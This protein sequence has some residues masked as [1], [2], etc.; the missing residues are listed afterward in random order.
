MSNN[1]KAPEPPS[2]WAGQLL[3]FTCLTALLIVLT[4][5]WNALGQPHSV[6]FWIAVSFP[7]MHQV[8]VWLAWR[9]ELHSS[10]V[11]KW[12]GFGGYLVAFFL[13]F[14]GRFLS[15]AWLAFLDRGSL[16]L[17]LVSHVLLTL[18][19]LMPGVYAMYSVRRYFGMA[20]AAGGDHFDHRFRDMPLVNK[21]IFRF[22]DNGMYLYAFLLFWAIAIGLNSAAALSVA[23]F[24]HAYIWVHFYATEKPDMDYLYGSATP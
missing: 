20:R 19:L 10:T 17:T 5:A 1:L 12:I 13:L 14:S 8:W 18:I 3:H 9:Y 4:L 7:V 11:S 6:A 15:L 22:T 21:G 23:A 16:K 24:S 2:L